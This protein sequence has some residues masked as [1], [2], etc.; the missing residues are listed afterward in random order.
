[1]KIVAINGRQASEELLHAAIRDSK[2]SSEPIQLI[3]ENTG[4]FKV[5]QLD[6]HGGELYPP[7]VR[8]EHTPARMEAILK[9]MTKH[10]ET[11]SAE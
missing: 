11:R 1:M 8:D 7:L 9:P 2:N 4:Y 5:V 6:Y 3:V 10:P